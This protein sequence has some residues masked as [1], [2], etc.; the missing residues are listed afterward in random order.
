M[1]RAPAVFTLGT[2][3]LG[4]EYGIT[5]AAGLPDDKEAERFLKAAATLDPNDVE[6]FKKLK[7]VEEKGAEWDHTEVEFMTMLMKKLPPRCNLSQLLPTEKKVRLP[8]LRAVVSMLALDAADCIVSL[9]A[10]PRSQDS[11]YLFL[12][13]IH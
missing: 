6:Y 5:N 2:A 9:L 11:D 8:S 4:M 3:Q 13:T 7:A 12:E 10:D 1:T